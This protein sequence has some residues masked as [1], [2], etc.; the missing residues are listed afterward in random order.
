MVA[1]GVD[2]G[3]HAIRRYQEEKRTNIS[4]DKKFVIAFTGVGSALTLA[5]IS[6]AI[7][8]L[9]NVTAATESIIH[10]GL[11]AGIAT[12]AAYIV[13]GIYAPFLLS[14]IESIDNKNN[15][16]KFIWIALA[17]GSAALS[18]GSVCLLY[19]SEAAD[20]TK[21]VDLDGRRIIK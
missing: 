6:D 8:F 11:A 13:L 12:F 7:A 16:N 4:Y 19:T 20:D 17:I 15:K 10:F 5:F 21:C 3:V 2:F 1:F 9:S 14:K 18:G